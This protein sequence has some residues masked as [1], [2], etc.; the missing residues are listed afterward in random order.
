MVDCFNGEIPWI[1]ALSVNVV[2][3]RNANIV[4]IVFCFKRSDNEHVATVIYNVRLESGK[5]V[6][7]K[8]NWSL[9]RHLD[10]STHF[11]GFNKTSEF[12]YLF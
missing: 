10:L 11:H 5:F 2:N 6:Y 9:V 3:L 4:N 7:S 1:R 8:D 12:L